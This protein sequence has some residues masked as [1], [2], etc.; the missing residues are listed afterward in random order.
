M[1]GVTAVRRACSAGTATSS[2]V[3]SV[4]A[5]LRHGWPWGP[6]VVPFL[7]IVGREWGL[8]V[9]QAR[10]SYGRAPQILERSAEAAARITNYHQ[11]LTPLPGMESHGA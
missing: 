1:D 4:G 9:V 5:L 3:S 10:L 2:C 11:S 8:S 6:V 7:A